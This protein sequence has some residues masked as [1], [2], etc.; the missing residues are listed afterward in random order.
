M[1]FSRFSV[2]LQTL[3]QT[4]SRNEM[5]RLLAALFAEAHEDEIDKICYLLLGRVAPL[6][7]PVEFG[8]ADKFMLR[9]VAA[10][11]GIPLAS[12]VVAFKKAG[13]VGSAAQ[14]VANRAKS[15]LT[16]SD[17]FDRLVEITRQ[18]GQGSQEQKISLLAKLL[19]GLDALSVRYV[20][21]IPLDKLRLGFSDMTI[22]DSLSW[23]LV[24][25]KSLRTKLEDA[26]NVRPDIGFLAKTVKKNGI[27]GL[28]R[29]GI[30]LGVPI[31]SALCQRLPTADEMV[32]K[33]GEVAVEPKYDGVR[34]QIHYGT[35]R[36][37]DGRS[38]RVQSYSRNLE[39][40]TAMFPELAAIGSQLAA[41]EAILDCEAVGIDRNGKLISFQETTTRKR[42]HDVERSRAAVPLKFFVFDILYKDGTELLRHPLSSRRTI[43]ASV[44]RGSDELVLSP[45]I[46]TSRAED[47]RR[48]HDE[49]RKKGLEGAVVKK[50]RSSYEPGRR[51]YSWVKFKEE[52][53]KT[54]KLTD[55]IDAVVMGYTRGEGKRTAFGIGQVI[56]GVRQKDGFV[57]VTKL[58]SG[59]T[60]KELRSLFQVLKKLR[61]KEQPK[62]YKNVNKAYYPDAW[63]SPRLVLEF[64]GDDLTKSKTH[65]AG[66]S[67]RFPRLVRIRTDKKPL[68]A[69][70][71][72]EV[73][74]MYRRQFPA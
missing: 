46:V 26:Y 25:D 16:V 54:G 68:D 7:E 35:M 24:G 19:G 34:V 53:G 40:T 22:L 36:R 57:T 52:E 23:M 72:A 14:L 29:V 74:A 51:G 17:V 9:A 2:H 42:K 60:E 3:E 1:L 4:A 69:T 55:T 8:V 5:T 65:G 45:Q 71:V 59:A 30:K 39:N 62:E 33:M 15:V 47:V 18:S 66:F 12:V 28:A 73:S 67:V 61:V 56:L 43:L 21:R 13:D 20:S 11:F 10:A 58:G 48:F 38:V 37:K 32:K 44:I 50:W 41:D 64:A 49:Q 31:L 70:T 6:F 27:P 63:V